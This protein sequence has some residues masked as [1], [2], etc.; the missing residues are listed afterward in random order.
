[1]DISTLTAAIAWVKSKATL[2]SW[3]NVTAHISV[4]EDVDAPTGIKVEYGIWAHSRFF[5]RKTLEEAVAAAIEHNEKQAKLDEAAKLRAEAAK[6]E[7][8][9]A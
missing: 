9:A 1:M 7:A 4:R 2:H 8:E 6:L 5:Y 3:D